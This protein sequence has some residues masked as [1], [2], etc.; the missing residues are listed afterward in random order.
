[1]GALPGKMALALIAAALAGAMMSFQ[2]AFNA[3]LQKRVNLL[4]TSIVVHVVGAVVT[5]LVLAGVLLFARY[6]VPPKTGFAEAP[7]WAYLGG[8]LS[9]VI[10]AGVALAFPITGAGLGVST[11]VTAQL[12][13]ALLLDQFGL[14][15]STRVPITWV[16]IV[17]VILLVIGTRLVANG[18]R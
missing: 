17:G 11:I 2:G 13:A 14:F 4:G 10:I 12:A 3:A 8:V 16:R 18:N 6:Y 5:G 9:V 15:E 7:W 1:M